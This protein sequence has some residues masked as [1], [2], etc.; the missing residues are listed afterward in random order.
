MSH[1]LQAATQLAPAEVRSKPLP[2]TVPHEAHE[3]A[4]ATLRDAIR[5]AGISLVDLASILDVTESRVRAKLDPAQVSAPI[6]LVDLLRLR[7][8]APEAWRAVVAAIVALDDRPATV[9]A[10]DVERAA[11]EL[12][13]AREALL[14]ILRSRR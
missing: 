9:P 8:R 14:Q 7:S 12:A 4:C 1:A 6:T 2:R 3:L 11:E 5:G 13:S 10:A